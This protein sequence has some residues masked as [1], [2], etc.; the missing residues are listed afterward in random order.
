MKAV[1]PEGAVL[2]SSMFDALTRLEG[3]EILPALATDWVLSDDNLTWTVSLREGV[4]FSNGEP[5]NANAVKYSFGR[6]LNPDLGLSIT[7]RVATI[8]SIEVVDDFTV[9]FVTKAP[10][11]LFLRRLAALY[12]IPPVYIQDVGEEVFVNSPVG[13]GAFRLVEYQPLAKITME[14]WDGS[15]RGAPGLKQLIVVVLPA[16]SARVTAL[17]SGDVDFILNVAPDD[18]R[19]LQGAGYNVVPVTVGQEIQVSFDIFCGEGFVAPRTTSCPTSDVLV[20]QAINYAVDKE[21]IAD[22]FGGFVAVMDGQHATPGT[23]GYN[24]DLDAYPYNP[25]LARELLSEAGYPDGFATSLEVTASA[26]DLVLVSEAVVAYLADVGIQVEI[27]PIERSVY[28]EHFHK[29]GRAPLFVGQWAWV[30]ALDSD[31]ALVWYS[32]LTNKPRRRSDNVDFDAAYI[33]STRE[34]DSAAREELLKAAH[35][36]LHEDPADLWLVSKPYIW[37]ANARVQGL[38]APPTGLL[39]FD[40]LSVESSN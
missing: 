1:G 9:R 17:Q 3:E 38:N 24:P 21:A 31:F 5:F 23:F 16:S 2:Y 7:A 25:E 14:A 34:M 15:W 13:T 20:R 12:I 18:A 10:D 28:L 11:P 4:S 27:M 33:A 40:Q 19:L 8:E 39:D 30:P 35:A 32:S 37:A 22:L 36:A 29:G 26:Q 6:G